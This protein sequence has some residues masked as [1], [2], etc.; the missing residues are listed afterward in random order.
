MEGCA[1]T[2]RVDTSDNF[3]RRTRELGQDCLS[4][5]APTAVRVGPITLEQ[6]ATSIGGATPGGDP[7]ARCLQQ[8]RPY[9]R[10]GECN[11]CCLRGAQCHNVTGGQDSGRSPCPSPR[12][13]I[14]RLDGVES[15]VR[16]AAR[17]GQRPL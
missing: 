4:G 5:P 10:V 14:D 8:R 17:T 3:C 11:G 7:P 12:G 2:N 6:W 16:L 15:A 1:G 9:C 13:H